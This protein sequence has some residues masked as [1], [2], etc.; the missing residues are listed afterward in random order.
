MAIQVV[1]P[2]SETVVGNYRE[3]SHQEVENIISDM[4]DTQQEWARTSFEERGNVM[5]QAGRLLKQDDEDYAR[6]ITEEMGK[7]ITQAIGEIHKCANLCFYYA[8]TAAD[9]LQDQPIETEHYRSY[10]CFEPLGIIFAI[11]PWNFPFWQALRFIVPNVMGG[12]AALLKHA[13]NSTA[14][15]LALEKL[16]VQAGFPQNIFRSLVID[17]EECSTVIA[18]RHI[19]GVTITGSEGAGA[20]VATEAGKAL[21][22]VVLELGGSDPYVVLDDADID[23]AVDQCVRS[24][25]NNAGQICISAKRMIVVDEVYEHF[26]DKLKKAIPEHFACGDPR[27]P[28]T[29]MGPMARK[30]LRDELHDKVKRSIE[31]GARCVLGGEPLEG[32]GYFYPPTLLLDVGPGMPAYD[33]ELFGPVVSVIK[34][35]DEAEAIQVANDTP[36]G[37]GGAVFTTDLARGER[38]AR[39]EITTGTCTVNQKVDSDQRLPFGGT[40][41]SGFGRELAAEGIREFMNIKTIVVNRPAAQDG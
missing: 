8:D 2:A 36:Y 16:F 20:A 21:K 23:L 24:R 40:K 3:M 37:L 5:R 13:P 27:N 1:N 11:M 7:P 38:I 19:K 14:A 29:T 15:A 33:E 10:R 32:T 22:K 12:N 18:H 34:V 6:I 4:Y 28:E 9:Y 35:A 17:V 41:R 31:N 39:H 26:V 30:D 25:L